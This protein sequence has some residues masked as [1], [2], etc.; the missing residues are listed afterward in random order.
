VLVGRRG[1]EGQRLALAPERRIEALALLLLDSERTRRIGLGV[2]VDEK[3]VD[4]LLRE[5]GREVDRGRGLADAAFLVGD[6]EDGG[7]LFCDSRF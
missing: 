3:G 6:G 7:G 2:E 4:L 5:P 1:D